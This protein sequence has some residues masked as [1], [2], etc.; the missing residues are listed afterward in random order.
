MLLLQL[1]LTLRKVTCQHK[2]NEA[3]ARQQLQGMEHTCYPCARSRIQ[4]AVKMH[5]KKK[6]LTRFTG[7]KGKQKEARKVAAPPLMQWSFEVDT[8]AILRPEAKADLAAIEEAL[9]GGTEPFR[10]SVTKTLLIYS[11]AT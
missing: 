8:D 6:V 10:A 3:T 1:L 5:K 9:S 11:G 4:V 2:S 7:V